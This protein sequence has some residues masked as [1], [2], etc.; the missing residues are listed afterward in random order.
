MTDKK[1]SRRIS[2]KTRTN[3]G[4]STTSQEGWHS[5]RTSLGDSVL[6]CKHALSNKVNEYHASRY[7]K[8][9]EPFNDD[10]TLGDGVYRLKITPPVKVHV[11][12]LKVGKIA[13]PLNPG[14]MWSWRWRKRAWSRTNSIQPYMM[15]S[16]V[17]FNEHI[18]KDC[19]FCCF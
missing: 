9:I 2:A 19:V 12:N 13:F 7:K 5:R 14:W 8:R 1:P 18:Q 4:S 3:M 10:Q 6:R 17:H 11:S 15:S 16:C